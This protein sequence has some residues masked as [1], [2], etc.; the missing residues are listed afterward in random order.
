MPL[1]ESLSG[2]PAHLVAMVVERLPVHPRPLATV[3]IPTT[4]LTFSTHTL[5]AELIAGSEYLHRDA[6]RSG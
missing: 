6:G 1:S 5:T 4:V 3:P 2:L